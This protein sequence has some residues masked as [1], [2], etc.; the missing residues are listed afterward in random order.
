MSL[1]RAVHVARDATSAGSPQVHGLHAAQ[2][3]L[4]VASL[5]RRP[6]AERDQGSEDSQEQQMSKAN[7]ALTE[8]L[9]AELND[10]VGSAQ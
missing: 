10:I 9:R 1:G 6:Q 4:L 3:E 5:E 2:L 8:S 7:A